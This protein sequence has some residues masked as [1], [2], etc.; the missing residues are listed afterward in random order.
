MLRKCQTGLGQKW[1]VCKNNWEKKQKR[2]RE[3]EKLYQIKSSYLHWYTSYSLQNNSIKI[4]FP[5]SIT[6]I[7]LISHIPKMTMHIKN[8]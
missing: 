1:H 3:R 2:E 4:A 7:N 6:N 8:H 5:Y